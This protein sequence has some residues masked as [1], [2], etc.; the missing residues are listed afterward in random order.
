MIRKARCAQGPRRDPGGA[1]RPRKGR[2]VIPAA[3][4]TRARAAA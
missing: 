2:G 1:H 3:R 4:I